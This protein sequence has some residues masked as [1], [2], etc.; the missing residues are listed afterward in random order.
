MINLEYISHSEQDTM[1][2][3]KNLASK[4]SVGDIIVLNGDLGAGKTKFTEGFLSYF[5]LE[6][7]ISSPTFT[8]VNEYDA[9]DLKIFHFDV[10]RLSDVDEFYAIGGEEYF[11]SGICIVEWGKII[12]D[13]L[14]PEYIEINI[15]VQNENER[16]FN[17]STY[18]KKYDSF[19]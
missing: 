16:I 8:I 19:F 5:N 11:N 4:L 15:S 7:E 18:G 17:I 2:F 14:P 3:A 1:D 13:A 12:Q 9:K 10:Y 6:Q